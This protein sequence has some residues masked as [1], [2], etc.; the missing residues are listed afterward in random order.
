MDYKFARRA[1]NSGQPVI[2]V[3]DAYMQRD[4]EFLAFAEG[5]P[6]VNALP[7]EWIRET[8]EKIYAEEMPRVLK[9]SGGVGDPEFREAIRNRLEKVRGI[10]TEGN[11]IQITVGG[12]QALYLS[13]RCFLNEGDQY[14]CEE[15][16]YAG[17]L[18]SARDF[19]ASPVAV[20][21]DEDGINIEDLEYKLQIIPNV[22]YI[23]LVPNFNNP[24]GVTLSWEKRKAVYE[25]AHKYDVMIIEDD[26]YGDLRYE[27]EDIPPIKT[28]DT[29]GR[30]VY[31]GTFSKTIAAGLRVGFMLSAN[32]VHE[33]LSANKDTIDSNNPML[34]QLICKNL[35]TQYDFE[36]NIANIRAYY[37]KKW[38]ACGDSLR[39]HIPKNWPILK[40]QGGMFY[41]IK[42]PEGVVEADVHQTCIE[43]KVGLVPSM[44][45]SPTPDR[46]AG[47]FRFCFTMMTPEQME[48][49][50]RRFGE[51]CRLYNDKLGLKEE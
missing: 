6:D 36:A 48:E 26:P 14:L 49:G 21:T 20:K 13:A 5:N 4:P 51:V 3:V 24:S 9:Y 25:L 31:L 11:D 33:I 12:Q 35:L 10:P 8:T 7:S 2:R 29:D 44:A 16:T 27:G 40:A 30:V 34:N 41:F 15:Y 46:P 32:P 22:K 39:K 28:I 37:T 50:A 38:K 1:V 45:F 43:H 19:N 18:D 47:G 17:M 23:Y 42:T